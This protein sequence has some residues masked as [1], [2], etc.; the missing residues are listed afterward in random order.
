MNKI[1]PRIALLESE[2]S[3]IRLLLERQTGVLLDASTE[4]LSDSVAAYIEES[5]LANPTDLL[6]RL[7]SSDSD[8]EA[9]LEHLLDGETSFFSY[10]EAF[11]CLS[12]YVLPELQSRKT[13]DGPLSLRIWSAGCSTGEEPYAIAV[14]VCQALNGAASWNV[15]IVGSD[16]RCEALEFA[17]RGLY[18]R[19]ALEHL[20][21]ATVHNYF[22][23][24]GEHFLVKPR[25]RNLVKFAPTNLARPHYIGRFDC[26]FCMKVMP[27]F[28]AAQR[29][30]LLHRLHLYLQPGGYLFL[31]R[32]EKLATA[33]TNFQS[34]VASEYTVY[35]K[36][37]AA[38]AGAGG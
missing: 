10:P 17:E 13:G 29:A 27:H 37:L 11:E 3:E 15:N 38:A 7:R 6:T 14:T 33:D 28:S 36:P 2:L 21:S 8:C 34:Q 24:V 5:R 12:T 35:R 32:G 25:I 22:A 4:K 31:G 23:K 18:P 16:I 9:L 26:I 20:P 19:S 1:L 30:A